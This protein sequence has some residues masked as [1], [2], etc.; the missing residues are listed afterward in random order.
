[1]SHRLLA[2]TALALAAGACSPGSESPTSG[3]AA[4]SAQGGAAPLPRT[5]WG[6][7]SIEGTYTN[8]DEYG[9]PFERPE[10]LAGKR[11]EDFGPNE[12]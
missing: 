9:T 1:M 11:R 10:A 12:M 8:K 7:P 4:A 6:D 3:A 5:S 2:V